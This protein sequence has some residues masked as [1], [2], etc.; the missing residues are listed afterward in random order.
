MPPAL[1]T[2]LRDTS[3]RNQSLQDILKTCKESV[4]VL[5]VIATPAGEVHNTALVTLLKNGKKRTHQYNRLDL[6]VI[7]QGVVIEARSTDAAIKELN[8]L[9]RCDFTADDVEVVGSYLQAKSDSL[10]YFGKHALDGSAPAGD[11]GG[12]LNYATCSIATD[13]IKISPDLYYGAPVVLDGDDEESLV[14]RVTW[15]VMINGVLYPNI[16]GL[17]NRTYLEDWLV[18]RFPDYFEASYVDEDEDNGTPPYVFI[19]KKNAGCVN[20]RLVPSQNPIPLMEKHLLGAIEDISNNPS[21][22]VNADGSVEFSLAVGTN[23]D[24]NSD[25]D[26]PDDDTPVYVPPS[27]IS[28][29]PQV[30][31]FPQTEDEYWVIRNRYYNNLNPINP[32]TDP[33]VRNVGAQSGNQRWTY[34]NINPAEWYMHGFTLD[35]DWVED[36]IANYT[37]DVYVGDLVVKGTTR[38]TVGALQQMISNS[39]LVLIDNR[40]YYV[41]I[42]QVSSP[43]VVNNLVRAHIDPDNDEVGEVSQRISI[44]FAVVVPLPG[45]PGYEGTIDGD[46]GPIQLESFDFAI[47][48]YIWTD[49][50]GRDLDTRTYLM[51]PSRKS[52]TVGWRRN[53]LDGDYLHWNGD[54]TGSGVE[55][56]LLNTVALQRDFPTFPMF[57]VSCNAFWYSSVSSGNFQV[58]FEMYKGGTME[59]VGYDFKNVGGQKTQT[60]TVPVNTNLQIS[61]DIDGTPVVVLEFNPE[62]MAGNL[63]KL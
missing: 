16:I 55:A 8:T 1:R 20:I 49:T 2:Q 30:K 39:D 23:H 24:Q 15:R 3:N 21:W 47:I 43:I 13:T 41:F 53:N 7:L 35:K 61:N 58:Q 11:N 36:I 12:G 19:R 50:G 40:Y 31:P 59:P 56:I 29:Y 4:R 37:Q 44:S 38:L 22:K 54:N 25:L 42:E 51:E 63:I 45:D 46:N 17:E 33:R 60:L 9:R 34:S 27:L 28:A 32:F 48:R 62:T 26:A 57:R 52:M 10:G 5:Q 18:E 6:A 14:D